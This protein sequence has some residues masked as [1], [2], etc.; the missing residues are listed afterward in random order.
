MVKVAFTKHIV[1]IILNRL[2]NRIVAA[3]VKGVTS[4]YAFQS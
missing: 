4:Q 1:R 2:R 3:L